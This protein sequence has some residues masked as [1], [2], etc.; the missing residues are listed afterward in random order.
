M[1]QQ[2]YDTRCFSA[3]LGSAF[4]NHLAGT[5]TSCGNSTIRNIIANS[6]HM[7]KVSSCTMPAME[8]AWQQNSHPLKFC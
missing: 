3:D 1:A 5:V 4:V 7:N 6:A 2:V 8:A